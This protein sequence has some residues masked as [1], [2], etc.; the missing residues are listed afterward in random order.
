MM[1]RLVL[2][3]SQ[4][5]TICIEYL[6][7]HPTKSSLPNTGKYIGV[8]V[9]D[10]GKLWLGIGRTFQSLLKVLYLHRNTLLFDLKTED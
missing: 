4:I 6:I 2:E 9:G 1:I 10:G 3:N 8:G 7:C 5:K